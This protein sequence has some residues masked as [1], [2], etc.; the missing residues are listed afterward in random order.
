MHRSLQQVGGGGRGT[1]R[2]RQGLPIVRMFVILGGLVRGA[3]RTKVRGLGGLLRVEGGLDVADG[4]SMRGK[5]G[6]KP[7]KREANT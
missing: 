6:E 5:E 1:W 3:A 7:H 2:W 4:W